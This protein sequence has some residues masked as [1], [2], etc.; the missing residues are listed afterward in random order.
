M[1]CINF[2]YVL[3]INK[4]PSSMYSFTPDEDNKVETLG[5]QTI[6]CYLIYTEQWQLHSH[7]TST[8]LSKWKA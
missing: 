4:S 3:C 1:Q 5:I 2:F 7:I 8:M 6:C